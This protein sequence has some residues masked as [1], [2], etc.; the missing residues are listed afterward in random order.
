MKVVARDDRRAATAKK[1]SFKVKGAGRN[2]GGGSPLDTS[3]PDWPFNILPK[4]YP[5]DAVR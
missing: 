5:F 3:R 4:G 2:G 1:R